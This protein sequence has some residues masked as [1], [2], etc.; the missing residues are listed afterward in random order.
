M[1]HALTDLFDA[2]GSAATAFSSFGGTSRSR[3]KSGGVIRDMPA[4][5]NPPVIAKTVL[6]GKM[7]A[8]KP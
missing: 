5:P 4:L 2:I 8:E 3:R 1:I 7:V 6:G